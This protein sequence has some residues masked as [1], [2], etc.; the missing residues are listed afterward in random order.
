WHRPKSTGKQRASGFQAVKIICRT[1]HVFASGPARFSTA[2]VDFSTMVLSM[3]VDADDDPARDE[4]ILQAAVDQ[5][6]LAGR[7][8]F[9]PWYT[10]HHFRGPWHSAPLEFAAYIAPQL[11]PERRLGFGVLGVPHH[12]P[13]RLVE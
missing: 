2:T 13:V 9:N 7:L 10:E 4:S 5:S 11:P 12:H 6:L 8:G 1:C 3:W